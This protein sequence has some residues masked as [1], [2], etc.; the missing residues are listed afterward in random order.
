[1]ALI[2]QG[3]VDPNA[4]Q[5]MTTMGLKTPRPAMCPLC[6]ERKPGTYT[7]NANGQV[8]CGDCSGSLGRGI[9]TDDATNPSQD[10]D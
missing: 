9:V 1:M 4:G 3:G 2:K 5:V 7:V 10:R 6:H 8:V